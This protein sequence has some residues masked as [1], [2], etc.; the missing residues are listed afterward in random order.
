MYV[1]IGFLRGMFRYASEIFALFF[2]HFSNGSN[3]RFL[4]VGFR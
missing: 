4:M 3:S 2:F 1:R